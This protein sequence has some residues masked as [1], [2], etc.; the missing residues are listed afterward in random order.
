MCLSKQEGWAPRPSGCIAAHS[1]L[2]SRFPPPLAFQDEQ[3]TQTTG[4]R[5]RRRSAQEGGTMVE[6]VVVFRREGTSCRTSS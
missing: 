1:L 3:L 4:A 6:K 2:S 5:A